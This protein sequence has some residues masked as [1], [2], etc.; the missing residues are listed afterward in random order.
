LF[1][2][3]AEEIEDTAG[4]ELNFSSSDEEDMDQ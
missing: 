1:T 3:E 4:E 2:E